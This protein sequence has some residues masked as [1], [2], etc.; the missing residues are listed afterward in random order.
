MAVWS[1]RRRRRGEATAAAVNSSIEGGGG[2]GGTKP[3]ILSIFFPLIDIL[4]ERKKTFER[5]IRRETF[6]VV[7][8]SPPPLKK[9]RRERKPEMCLSCSE[10]GGSARVKKLRRFNVGRMERERE[11]KGEEA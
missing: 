5:N 3:R 2:T 10:E 4:G 1:G 8:F 6:A 11:R 7:P 9:K